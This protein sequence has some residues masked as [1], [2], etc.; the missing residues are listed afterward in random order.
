MI[1]EVS[2]NMTGMTV[3]Y[4]QWDLHCHAAKMVKPSMRLYHVEKECG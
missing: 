2:L 4:V 3:T 1:I